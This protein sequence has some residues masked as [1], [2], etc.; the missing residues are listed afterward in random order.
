MKI[1]SHPSRP[2]LTSPFAHLTVEEVFHERGPAPA[3]AEARLGTGDHQNPFAGRYVE[4][5]AP[6]M[7]DLKPLGLDMAR[8]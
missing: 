7:D 4:E 5:I 3:P 6:Y 8:R 2:W 1:R